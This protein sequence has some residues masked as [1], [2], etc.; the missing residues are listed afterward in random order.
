MELQI[1][2]QNLPIS[3]IVFDNQCEQPVECDILLPDYCPDV[4]RILSCELRC[5]IGECSAQ[6]QRISINGE[7]RLNILYV[8]DS[9][10]LR[11]MEQKVPFT[12]HLESKVL[13]QDPMIEV[14]CKQDYLNCRAVSSRRLEVRGAVSLKVRAINCGKVELL[15]DAEGEGIQLKKTAMNLNSCVSAGESDFLIREEL[16]LGNRLP[17]AQ[18]LSSRVQAQLSDYKLIS[19]K[20]VSKGELQL[21]LLYLPL[22]SDEQEG[23]QTLEYS[24]PISQIISAAAVKEDSDICLSYEVSGWDLQPKADLD[25]EMKVLALEVKVRAVASI[26]Q[27]QSFQLVQD[28]YSTGAVL[29]LDEKQLSPLNFEG[30]IQRTQ[31]IRESFSYAGTVQ[32]LL[33]SWVKV[34]D[35]QYR[36][37]EDNSQLTAAVSLQ[38]LVLDGEG[39]YQ[40][41]EE[42]CQVEYNIP[43]SPGERSLLFQ[44]QILPCSVEAVLNNNGHLELRGQLILS[45]SLYG[46]G[47]L[48]ALTNLSIDEST[49]PPQKEDCALCIYYADKQESIWDIGKQ[50][51]S[52]V[53][54]IMEEN[55]LDRDILPQRTMLLIPIC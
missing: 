37:N 12:R 19:D 44:L 17:I 14:L 11:G 18:I 46:I 47:Q 22:S 36:Q 40:L 43:L 4:Q 9:G 1:K 49:P 30:C 21:Q 48:K 33:D 20:I 50:Y 23:P 3:E 38:A 10:Q 55:G 32:T 5:L 2:K 34:R 51:N 54:A 25:G 16:E 35:I 42:K 7:L 45:G 8:S 53:T 31:H 13:L 52:S 39:S 27:S 28:A 41:L 6:Q 15:E 26:H 29:K 24:L